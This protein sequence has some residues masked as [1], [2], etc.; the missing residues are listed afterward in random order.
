LH[1]LYTDP[2]VLSMFERIFG[3]PAFAHPMFI[4]RNIFP[5]R[6]GFDFTTGVHQDRIH[7]G[8]ATSY[9]LWLPLGDCP[10]EK[11]GLAVAAGSHRAG[12]FDTTVGN[13][14][15]GMEISG[16]ISG[17]WVTG[18]FK[19]GDA[20]VFADHTAHRALPN[21]TREIRQS[22]DARYQRAS[23]PV[24]DKNLEPYAGTGTWEEIYATW[25]STDQQY[26][27]RNFDLQVVPFD[28]SYYERRDEMAFAMA[29]KGDLSTRDTLLRIAQRDRSSEKRAR[30]EQLLARLQSGS[31]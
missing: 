23:Q 15:G 11:G 27:W 31:G 6:E 19:A 4:Q 22:V 18:S 16:P 29:E 12:L 13:G 24:A 5:Q 26:Y 9:A 10:P 3:E 21:R 28:T 25:Q 7:I 20:L 30:A 17:T 1:R 8:G 14:A 2:A